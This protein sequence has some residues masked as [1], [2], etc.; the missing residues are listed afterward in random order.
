M[1][2]DIFIPII[3]PLTTD[4]KVCQKSV[5]ALME[6]TR[7]FS[8]GY[9]PCLTSGEGW[10]LTDEQ[11]KSMISACVENAKG[12]KIIAGIEKP[13]SKNVI[14]FSKLAESLGADAV[15]I[16]TPFGD[17]VSQQEIYEHFESIHN[18]IT[19]DIFIY[20][21]N[22]LSNNVIETDTLI[23]TSKL[24]RVVGIKESMNH[25][26][27]KNVVSTL[28]KN[29]ISIYQGWENRIVNDDLSDGNICSLSNLYPD[30]CLKAAQSNSDN[31]LSTVE[32][33]CL[34]NGIYEEHWYKYIKKHLH[35][36]N[37]ISTALALS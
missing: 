7:E 25:D 37:I 9:V 33:L 2:N 14:Q 22:S 31:M 19:L 35:A 8:A 3:T 27:D 13:L 18:S 28:K 36:S 15:M 16:T 11:W 6:S 12:C 5:H 24:E 20:N 26:F 4:L 30:I 32:N 34:K 21:E 29:G 1:K 10:L 23:N 17:N